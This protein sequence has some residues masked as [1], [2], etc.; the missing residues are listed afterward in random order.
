[1]FLCALGLAMAVQSARASIEGSKHDF[2]SLDPDAAEHAALVEVLADPG[3]H[4]VGQGE[5]V[6]DAPGGAA[7]ERLFPQAHLVGAGEDQEP[8]VR[9]V[10]ASERAGRMTRRQAADPARPALL[11]D[12]PQL[13]LHLLAF[14]LVSGEVGVLVEDDD[15]LGVVTDT[16]LLRHH[17]KSPFHLLKAV[18]RSGE[19]TELADYAARLSGIVETMVASGLDPT[20]EGIALAAASGALP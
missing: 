2:R 1:M 18:E 9:R 12:T 6:E 3:D 19:M 13:F 5:V 10:L 20:P 15:V 16:D 4:V 14:V 7:V 8:S 11:G 17:L